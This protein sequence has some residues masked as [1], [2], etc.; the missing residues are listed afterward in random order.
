LWPVRAAPLAD[1]PERERTWLDSLTT[2]TLDDAGEP[3]TP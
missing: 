3:W 1:T 2:A